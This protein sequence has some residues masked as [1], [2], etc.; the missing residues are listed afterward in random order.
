MTTDTSPASGASHRTAQVTLT[1]LPSGA[2]QASI[3]LDGRHV[4]DT[5]MGTI[6]PELLSAVIPTLEEKYRNEDPVR[7]IARMARYTEAFRRYDKLYNDFIMNFRELA[8]TYQKQAFKTA[9]AKERTAET[10]DETRLL[11]QIASA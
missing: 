11:Q 6:E 5:L 10:S 7:R 9:E 4:Y 1:P 8:A 2:Q 3:T